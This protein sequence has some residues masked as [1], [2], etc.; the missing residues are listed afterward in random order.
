MGLSRA[1]SK[2]NNFASAASFSLILALW[3]IWLWILAVGGESLQAPDSAGERGLWEASSA[4]VFNSDVLENPLR[5]PF[6]FFGSD[7]IRSGSEVMSPPR[8]I[9][10]VTQTLPWNV[11]SWYSCTFNLEKRESFWL[12]W[13]LEVW[14]SSMSFLNFSYII[15]FTVPCYEFLLISHYWKT[16]SAGICFYL[17]QNDK[18]K[19]NW[20]GNDFPDL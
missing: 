6:C 2:I 19:L 20:K 3:Y 10:H 18:Y 15:H 14:R 4:Q 7:C 16:W 9:S 13:D 12:W 5:E 8:G 17:S 1:Y 11:S